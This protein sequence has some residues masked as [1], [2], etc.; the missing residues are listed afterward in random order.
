MPFVGEPSLDNYDVVVNVRTPNSSRFSANTFAIFGQDENFDEW[1]SAWILFWT[2]ELTFRPTEQIRVEGRY[3][4][5]QYWRKTDWSSVRVRQ[6]PRLKLEYQLT[7]AIFFRFVGQYD[8][9]NVDDLR[10]DSRTEGR[11]VVSDGRGGFE[12]VLG[13]THNDFSYDLLF[14]FEP[15]PGTVIFAGF[16]SSLTESE[17]FRFRRLERTHDGF[18]AKLSYLFRT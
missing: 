18:F 9:T 12:P 17:S 11:I 2:S 4:L 6:I 13:W 5:Q 8:A 1:A 15:S 16:G 14:S 3:A 10:D 7:R